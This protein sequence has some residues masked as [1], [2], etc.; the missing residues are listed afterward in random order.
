M[1]FRNDIQILRAVAVIFVVLY[2]LHTPGFTNGLLGVDVFYAISGFLM[3][4]IYD[5]A[6]GAV[7]FYQRRARRLLP[8]YFATILLTMIGC[9]LLTLPSDFA[10]SAEQGLYAALFASNIGFWMKNTYF[11]KVDFTPLLHLWSL[12]VE[13]QFYLFVPLIIRLDKWNRWALPALVAGSLALCLIGLKLSPNLSFF[14][15]PM[16]LW[17]FGL[18]MLAARSVGKGDLRPGFG[19]V[20]L[21]AVILMLCYPTIGYGSSLITGH[22]GLG[23]III[24][25]A[26]ALVLRYGLPDVLAQY[27]LGRA[28][29]Y[30]GDISYSVYLV[31]F[32]IIVLYNYQPFSGT[33]LGAAN[34][35]SYALI[36]VLI[37]GAGFV[38]HHLFEK[39]AVAL[40]SWRTIPITSVGLLAIS[41]LS[42]AIQAQAYDKRVRNISAAFADRA[43]Y[44]CGATFR[45]LHFHD[46]F[47]SF[48]PMGTPR[49]TVLLVG[50]SHADAIKTSFIKQAN[51]AG[52]AV[53]F[54]VSNDPL[55]KPP[56]DA[57]WLVAAAQGY[58][59]KRVFIHYS[60]ANVKP[61]ILADLRAKL[62]NHGI[63]MTFIMPV[64]ARDRIIP[65]ILLEAYKAG[66][67]PPLITRA[68][69]ERKIAAIAVPMRAAHPGYQVIEPSAYL[70]GQTCQIADAD[71]HPYYFDKH[72]LTLS[73]ARQLEPAF[74]AAIAAERVNLSVT[75]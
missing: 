31:H 22:P 3:Y 45:I 74:K 1:T 17:Q 58:G 53:A 44:R 68:D 52:L 66:K 19:S 56:L 26:T 16:R 6:K 59:A 23:A 57:D 65:L 37:C 60:L 43:T 24:T 64:P 63:A 72:H 49:G 21:V 11:S 34:P 28:M 10:Q 2:H 41:W 14:M 40:V 38:F 35:F 30:I 25:T 47:C 42:P 48:A 67:P 15:M 69:Y 5:H 51:A 7:G 27:S 50:D 71:S 4:R 18:G 46:D 13:L 75:D 55:V 29:K 36:I 32:P 61:N 54:S 33:V 62:W 39:R 73:G 70:C 20:A 9:Y 8:G 12:A